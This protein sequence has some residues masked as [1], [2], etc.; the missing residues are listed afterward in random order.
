MILV[1]N[2]ARRQAR[3]LDWLYS[4][5]AMVDGNDMCLYS[6][7]KQPLYG[8]GKTHPTTKVS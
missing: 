7:S 2:A 1:T 6:G 3:Q 5:V 8:N 4:P